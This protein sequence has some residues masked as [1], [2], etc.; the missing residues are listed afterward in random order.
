MSGTPTKYYEAGS[1]PSRSDWWSVIVDIVELRREWAIIHMLNDGTFE[2]W[3]EGSHYD[4]GRTMQEAERMME[5]ARRDFAQG[6]L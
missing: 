1:D 2:V 3:A 4:T 6:R 5:Q